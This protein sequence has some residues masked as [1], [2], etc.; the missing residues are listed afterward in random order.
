MRF[1]AV[2]AAFSSY[3]GVITISIVL[4]GW[5]DIPG[6]AVASIPDDLS[7]V[8]R[9]TAAMECLCKTGMPSAR[10]TRYRITTPVGWS[11]VGVAVPGN[12]L[13]ML[14]LTYLVFMATPVQSRNQW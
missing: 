9:R 10:S 6:I 11:S 1:G 5:I 8:A 12:I 14:Y 4:G 7:A 2:R 13:G 3:F